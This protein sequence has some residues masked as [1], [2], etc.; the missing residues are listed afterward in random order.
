MAPPSPAFCVS[1]A[2]LDR[3]DW[4]CWLSFAETLGA[5]RYAFSR[6][7]LAVSVYVGALLAV[8]SMVL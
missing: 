3:A 2:F 7:F 1:W 6:L 5:S 8:A 4:A